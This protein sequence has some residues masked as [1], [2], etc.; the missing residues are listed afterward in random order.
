[1]RGAFLESYAAYLDG[2]PLA[3][4]RYASITATAQARS[5][6]QIPAAFRDGAMRVASVSSSS[7]PFSAQ[8]AVVLAN[9]EERYPL[10]LQ[11][12]REQ[13]GWQVAQLQPPDLTVDE[14]L[15]PPAGVAIPAAAQSAT[16]RF[17]VAYAA[18]R[19]GV[20]PPPA[21]MTA[22]AATALRAGQD[23]L[24]GLRLPALAPQL[25]SVAYGPLSGGEFAATVSVRFG[26][27]AERFSLLMQLREQ[28][29]GWLCAAFL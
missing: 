12:L 9:R 3:T 15:A 27:T 19:A 24:A 16:R 21:S 7:S 2:A 18:Y 1:V 29:G 14:T 22:A 17:A 28:A 10:Q 4:L 5:G 23:A 26:T 13:H 11:L 6:G 25:G 8:A 20:A